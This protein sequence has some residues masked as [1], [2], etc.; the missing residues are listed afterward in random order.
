MYTPGDGTSHATVSTYRRI[1][2]LLLE[3]VSCIVEVAGQTR[4]L[5]VSLD[6]CI[7]Q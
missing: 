2:T 3:A 1:A 4:R 7:P 6:H 5:A